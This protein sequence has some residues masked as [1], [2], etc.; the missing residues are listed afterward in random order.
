MGEVVQRGMGVRDRD[1]EVGEVVWG[2]VPVH[3]QGCHR[4]FVTVDKCY[5]SKK[6]PNLTE[7]DASG[8]L[9]AGLTAWSGLFVTGGLGGP[10]GALTSRGGGQ[11]KRVLLLG[12][13]GGVGSIAAQILVAEGALVTATCATDAV[14]MVRGLG[15]PNVIDYKAEDVYARLTVSGPFDLVLDCAGK[16]STYA[17]ELPCQFQQYV[18]FSSPL[19]RNID[20]HGLLAGNVKNLLDLVTNNVTSVGAQKGVVKWGY[21][22]PAP[23][24]IAYL[25]KL[26]ET[27][28]L[29][30]ITQ[31]VY[32]FV[33]ADAAYKKVEEGHL[34]GKI[35]LDLVNDI[36]AEV[37]DSDS[38]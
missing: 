23:H 11:G 8:V 7:V 25:R 24:G 31:A 15:V 3:K 27:N 1:V 12:A 16:S 26:V 2:V 33:A 17:A 22:L 5:I 19:L 30:P 10:Q 32:S 37:R 21:F 14:E 28:K 20:E 35:I 6:P 29:R 9:Y 4:D 36:K 38:E 34:R 13:A 18:T